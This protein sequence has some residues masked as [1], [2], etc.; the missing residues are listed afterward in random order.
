V[1]RRLHA[2]AV[3]VALSTAIPAGVCF[4]TAFTTAEVGSGGSGRGA[5]AGSA[6]GRALPLAGLRLLE[7]SHTVM[8]DEG[9]DSFTLSRA[10]RVCS[11]VS[12]Y[13]LMS[14][15]NHHGNVHESAGQIRK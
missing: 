8:V 6:E 2:A 7:F 12:V 15:N 4:K 9:G 14:L 10:F 3:A 5:A 13:I 11:R 1:C